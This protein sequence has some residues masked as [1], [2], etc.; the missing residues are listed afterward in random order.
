LELKKKK[1]LL[2][3]FKI[4]NGGE[5]QDGRQ[6]IKCS[7]IVRNNANIATSDF[8]RLDYLKNIIEHFFC[9]NYKMAE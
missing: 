4:Q 1:F 3:L 8:G 9:L 2:A 5:I 6:T 7:R